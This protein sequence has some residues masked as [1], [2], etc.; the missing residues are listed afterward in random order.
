MK[1]GIVIVT[2]YRL[3]EEFLQAL[4]LIVPDAPEFHSVSVEPTQT[5]DEM[6]GKIADALKAA[7]K[8]HGVLVLTDM[9]RRHALEHRAVVPRRA[10]RRGA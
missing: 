2:H 3:G 7:D 5:V 6:R 8:G 9:F 4:R 1:P 10:P